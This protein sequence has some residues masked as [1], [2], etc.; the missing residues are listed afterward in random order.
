MAEPIIEISG[1]KKSFT[2][3]AQVVPVLKGVS[4]N[5]NM[6]DFVIIVGPSGCG[7]STLLHIILGLEQPSEG[8]IVFLG[9]NIY[10]NTTEDYRSDFRKKHIG[11]VYQQPNWVKSMTVA[12]NVAFPMFL[13]GME[14]EG[15]LT[16]AKELLTQL[17][18]GDWANY[19]PSELSGG[20]QQRVSLA[21]AL[22]NNPEIII[23]DEPTG[24]LDYQTGQEVMQMLQEL[25]TKQQKT[26]VMVTHDLEYL[27]YA[28]TAIKIFDGEIDTIYTGDEI[29]E[30]FNNSKQKRGVGQGISVQTR[31][32]PE[33]KDSSKTAPEPQTQTTSEPGQNNE[34][35]PPH[36]AEPTPTQP[37]DPVAAS[38]IN[39]AVKTQPEV[40]AH[41]PKTH[42]DRKPKHPNRELLKTPRQPKPPKTFTMKTT[43]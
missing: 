4:A 19:M 24:N 13:L 15:A 8:T 17:R 23:A 37:D 1:V 10:N 9:E 3:G 16:R 26:V 35:T 12:E 2:V 38:T 28:N 14:V 36:Q 41:L 20:Q 43:L 18:M 22:A 34:S 32:S 39:P 33:A 6:G 21:R 27:K 31:T 30:L 7:K 40:S 11:M 42:P 25:N 5:I 29:N